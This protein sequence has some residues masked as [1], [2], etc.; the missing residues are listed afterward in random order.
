MGKEVLVY[1]DVYPPSEDSFLLLDSAIPR[2]SGRVLDLCCGTG[3]VGLF[4]SDK[5]ESVT[6]I[7]L[8]PSAVKNTSEN[9]RLNG[10]YEKLFA[11]VGDLFGP[12]R[13][14]CYD[15]IV[16]NP[17]YL[18]DS[19]LEPKDPS[20]SGGESGRR[21][22]DRFIREV[23]GY[24]NEC[25]R[26]LFVQSTLNGVDESLKLIEEEGMKGRV[27]SRIDFMFEGLVVIEVE[28]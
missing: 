26:A 5:A 20:W 16:M 7:D 12:L 23:G 15:L 27:V 17:P 3:F 21:I 25:G 9:F 13:R 4:L 14:D 19:D 24:M 1:P 18:L 10:S 28:M 6:A 2:A 8:N 22:I 11:V